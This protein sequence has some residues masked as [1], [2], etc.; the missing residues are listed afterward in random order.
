MSTAQAKFQMT[1]KQFKSVG[2]GDR[3]Q[4]QS[5]CLVCIG[6]PAL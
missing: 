2:W 5:A 4:W 3:T 1:S 6:F